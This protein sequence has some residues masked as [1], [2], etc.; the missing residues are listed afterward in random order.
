MERILTELSTFSKASQLSSAFKPTAALRRATTSLGAHRT[1]PGPANSG[2]GPR[3]PPTSPQAFV[4]K[5][6]KPVSTGQAF[7]R[8]KALGGSAPEEGSSRG[9]GQSGLCQPSQPLSS[10]G[11][12]EGG[13]QALP[14]TP[15]LTAASLV[16]SPTRFPPPR[17]RVAPDAQDTSLPRG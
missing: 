16:P 8:S 11:G 17:S 12:W 1:L 14:Y 13:E 3:G 9:Q 4:G 6:Q 7:L 10:F 5:A 15:F 2:L